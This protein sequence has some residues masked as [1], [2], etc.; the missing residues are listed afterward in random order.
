MSIQLVDVDRRGV[1]L[2]ALGEHDRLGDPGEHVRVGHH[3]LGC[4]D[5][6]GAVDL[7]GA[8]GGDAA[9]LDDRA[10]HGFD[11]RAGLQR[12][13]GRGD[14]ADLGGRERIE[15]VGQTAAG[16][17]PRAGCCRP[18]RTPSGTASSTACTSADCR[19]WLD[20]W[21]N[22]ELAS[23]EATIQATSSTAADETT[24]PATESTILAGSQVTRERSARPAAPARICPSSA[25]ASTTTRAANTRVTLDPSMRSATRP[26]QLR[27]RARPRPGTRG[28]RW[29]RP[30]APAGSR[31][32]RTTGRGAIS[33]RST[34]DI[35][36][37][38]DRHRADLPELD[39]EAA[40]E[41]MLAGRRHVELDRLLLARGPGRRC[42]RRSPRDPLR[43]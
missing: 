11:D 42:P 38:P 17:S 18:L 32:G 26:G 39:M 25:P 2:L 31:R 30:A 41:R 15:D 34:T 7:P 43:S 16:R 4:V 20:T 29:R 9:D 6:A 22:G 24:A 40:L 33:T 19:T 37:A 35:G 14:V 1:V 5:E 27:A 23:G 12:R 10:L 21:G 28:S 8:R 3:P 13:V 36:S